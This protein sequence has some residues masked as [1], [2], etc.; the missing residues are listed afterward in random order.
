VFHALVSCSC[1]R[2]IARAESASPQTILLQANRLGRYCQLFHE[3]HRPRGPI[4]EP[5][6]LD[7]F[8]SF[9][10]SQ[11]HPTWYHVVA[12]QD[13]HFF[14]GFTDSELRRSGSMTRSQ[15]R[16]RQ[17]IEGRFG[18]P[19]PRSIELESAAVL[20][21]VCRGSEQ[22]EL[23]TDRHQDYPRAIKRLRKLKVTHR[24]ISSRARRDSINPLFSINL[25]DLLIRHGGANHKR[26]TIA[27]PKRRQMASARLWVTLV[28]RNYLKWVSEKK[29]ADTPAMRLG[30]FKR[31]LRVK[32]ILKKRLFVTHSRLP[33]RWQTY[34][35]GRTPT[36]LMPKGRAHTLWY[37]Q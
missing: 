30:I 28:W 12:G 13:S 7:G 14:H 24:T 16:T 35:W 5:L 19:D 23:H 36:R 17:A 6:A 8:Q 1:L 34:Y 9:E 18:K 3:R 26:E 27:F 10:Y 22:V 29:H 37:A 11:F 25:L 32:D 2:Q 4:S 31:R 21:I 20:R 15:K 33:K